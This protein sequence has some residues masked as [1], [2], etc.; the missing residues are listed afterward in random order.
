MT[1]DDVSDRL[2][3][4]WVPDACTLPTVEQPLRVAELDELF[5]TALRTQR[6]ASTRLRWTLDPAAEERARDLT[7][8]E[9]RCCS[10]FTFTFT[11]AGDTLHLDVQVPAA[12]VHVLDALAARAAA[13]GTQP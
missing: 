1:T 10:L 2:S 13:A 6:T 7:A 5:S 12:Q 8:R 9:S 11:P 4:G 3:E